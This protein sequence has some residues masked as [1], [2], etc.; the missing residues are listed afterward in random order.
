MKSENANDVGKILEALAA[1]RDLD[2]SQAHM[3]FVFGAQSAVQRA[4]V[5]DLRAKF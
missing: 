5:L 2:E 4:T 1:I 3:L